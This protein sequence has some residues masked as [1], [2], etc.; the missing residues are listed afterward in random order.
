MRLGT[1][2]IL[3]LLIS[4]AMS[5]NCIETY[6]RD[7]MELW[8]VPGNSSLCSIKRISDTENRY[9]IVVDN[10]KLY[11]TS[12]DLFTWSYDNYVS[13]K[14]ASDKDYSISVYRPNLAFAHFLTITETDDAS[15]RNTVETSFDE[16]NSAHY[17]SRHYVATGSIKRHGAGIKVFML[18]ALGI[19]EGLLVVGSIFTNLTKFGCVFNT[20]LLL[21]VSHFAGWIQF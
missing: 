10:G 17:R 12:K 9:G 6:R 18:W 14:G 19:I 2:L 15:K 11:V 21:G 1:T 4:S 3:G 8:V 5:Q 16:S 20:I 13:E 7:L